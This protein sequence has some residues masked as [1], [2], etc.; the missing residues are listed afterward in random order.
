MKKDKKNLV[1]K[2]VKKSSRPSSKP[3]NKQTPSGLGSHSGQEKQ[4]VLPVFT[5]GKDEGVYNIVMA[6]QGSPTGSRQLL[7]NTDGIQS[8]KQLAGA[9]ESKNAHT[10][11]RSHDFWRESNQSH[12]NIIHG[13][14]F[15]TKKSFKT[16]ED[17]KNLLSRHGLLDAYDME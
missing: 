17:Q 9:K 8:P 16:S 6:T 15:L 10:V 12:E 11:P 5:K 3:S 1:K 4:L 7:N 13:S 14:R 2:V